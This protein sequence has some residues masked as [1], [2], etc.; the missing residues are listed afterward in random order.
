[1]A[2]ITRRVAPK[3][4]PAKSQVEERLLQAI[5]R[6]VGTGHSFTALSIDQLAR[7]AGV[8]R[9]TFYLHFSN[10]GD[11]V[12][13]I[14]TRIREEIF[15][16]IDVWYQ[17]AE[18]V[19]IAQ[20]RVATMGMLRILKQH[21]CILGAVSETSAYDPAVKKLQDDMLAEICS[22]SLKTMQRVKLSGRAHPEV[23]AQAVELLVW[24][25]YHGGL[26]FSR[27]ASE[28]RLK[29]LAE[30]FSHVFCASLFDGEPER[31]H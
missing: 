1:M 10:K 13:R 31:G 23:S 8:S 20:V 15:A 11:L 27:D 9:G 26:N 30:A 17:K 29:K 14:L 21:N 19:T 7:E 22:R 28:A 3:E 16:S 2:S 12:A 6:L 18:E 24:L 4:V 25:S 5:E